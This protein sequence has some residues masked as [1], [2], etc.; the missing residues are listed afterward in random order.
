MKRL[1]AFT[2]A[3]T[4]S[5]GAHA[6]HAAEGVAPEDVWDNVDAMLEDSPHV[7]MDVDLNDM[8]GNLMI[9][10]AAGNSVDDV[11]EE[12]TMLLGKGYTISLEMDADYNTIITVKRAG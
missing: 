11:L 4:L 9:S 2:A 8:S 5:F 6:H 10:P 7:T 1:L 3:M 12:L